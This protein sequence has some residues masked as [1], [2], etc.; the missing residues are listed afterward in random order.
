MMT[1]NLTALAAKATAA[2]NALPA[3]TQ[4]KMRREQAISFVFG[5][6]S[7]DNPAITREMV[8]A[9]YDEVKL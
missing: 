7:L 1:T 9:A 4:R 6:L 2:F 8:A 5:N 3:E